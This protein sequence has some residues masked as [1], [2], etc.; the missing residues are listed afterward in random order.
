ML[1]S[2]S[3]HQLLSFYTCLPYTV[4]ISAWSHKTCKVSLCS[5]S[6]AQALWTLQ[7]APNNSPLLIFLSPRPIKIVRVPSRSLEAMFQAFGAPISLV[8]CL[9]VIASFATLYAKRLRSNST[10][11]LYIPQISTAGGQKKRWMFD[12]VN[13][14]Q[15]GYQRV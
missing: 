13:L 8:L 2:S 4:S 15:E 14:L 11:P 3:L 6:D 5:K 9:A 1:D 12:S 7:T 10:I